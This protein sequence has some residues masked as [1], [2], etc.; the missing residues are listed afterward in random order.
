MLVKVTANIQKMLYICSREIEFICMG[1]EKRVMTYGSSALM[2]SKM[3][4][5]NE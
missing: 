5:K 3:N 4:N 1:T 2:P